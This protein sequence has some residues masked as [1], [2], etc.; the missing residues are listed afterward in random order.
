MLGAFP[1]GMFMADLPDHTVLRSAFDGPFGQQMERAPA[2][3]AQR[4]AATLDAVRSSGHMELVADFAVPVPANVLFD[5]LG[6]PDTPGVRGGLQQW[7]NLM[8]PRTTSRSRRRS[9]SPAGR[10]GWRCW[11]SWRVSCA[12]TA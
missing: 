4:A 10:R 9:A 2:I 12:S 6:I 1:L 8:V 7:E 11:P 3:A 5:I